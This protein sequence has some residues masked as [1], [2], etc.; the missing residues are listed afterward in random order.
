LPETALLTVEQMAEADRLTIQNGLSG[1]KL[2]EAAG[3]SIVREITHRYD[4]T[5]VLILC[6][7]GNNGGD[8]FVIARHLQAAGWP[9]ELALLGDVVNL[10]GDAAIMAS[11]WTGDILP[12]GPESISDQDMIIDAIFGAGLSRDIDGPVAKTLQKANDHKAIRIAV[13]IPSGINGNTGQVAGQALKADLT[14]TFFRQKP[15]HV[16][17]PGKEH[18]G[19]IIVTDIGISDRVLDLINP[20]HHLNAPSLW[21]DQ[22]PAKQNHGHKYDSGHAVVCSG[23]QAHTGASR[24][25]AQAALRIGAGLVSVACPLNAVAVH[26]AH[27]TAV[28]IKSYEN[29]SNFDLLLQDERLNAWCL[30]PANGVHNQ[31][32]NNVLAVLR[33]GRKTV[34]D[35]DALSVFADN[36]NDLFTEVKSECILTPHKGEFIR[37][38]PDLGALDKISATKQA[39]ERSGAVVLYK[40]PDTVIAAPDGRIIINNHAP[41]DLATAGSGDVLAGLITGLMAQGM[42]AF[43]SAAAATWIH[44]ES[45]YRFGP[46]LTAEDIEGQIP[47]ILR[48]F[49]AK[50]R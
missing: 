41:A 19:E 31:T 5:S 33:A 35:A 4:Q 15:G 24:L 25:A 36:P 50:N 12:L 47:S 11:L 32:R 9:V 37:L 48:R 49:R 46:G 29:D 7:P 43:K 45:A 20:D 17:Y 27:L 34:L 8:G 1:E 18:C 23:D 16:L 26:A 14:V 39:A 28:M 10:K 3:L 21:F 42:P 40:G 30:G 6:G 2:M 44:G 13:D 22:L 38:F